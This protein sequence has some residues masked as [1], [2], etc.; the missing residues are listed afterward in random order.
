[1]SRDGSRLIKSYLLLFLV[2]IFFSQKKRLKS[3]LGLSQ[4]PKALYKISRIRKTVAKET[5]GQNIFLK[6]DKHE[7]IS[8]LDRIPLVRLN[9]GKN[10]LKHHKVIICGILRDTA[11]ELPWVIRYVEMTGDLFKDYKVVV[12][13]NDSKDETKKILL[14]WA[15][16]NSRVTYL[17]KNYDLRRRPSLKFLAQSRNEYLKEITNNPEY[18]DSFDVLMILDFDALFGWDIKGI[19]HTFSMYE[20]WDVACANGVSDP[21]GKMHD[22]FAF[23]S[24]EFNL[25]PITHRDYWK[26]GLWGCP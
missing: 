6:S 5:E 25:S 23:R 12:F 8:N 17:S 7:H 18:D 13:E 1:M 4:C 26:G 10:V 21:I 22:V 14:T 24:K 11:A 16:Q 20:K 9:Q 15:F 2:C 19:Y 3:R